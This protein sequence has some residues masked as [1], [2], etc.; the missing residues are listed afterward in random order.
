MLVSGDKRFIPKSGAIEQDFTP[1]MIAGTLLL[2]ATPAINGIGKVGNLVVDALNPL[3]GMRNASISTVTK[4]TS[5]KVKTTLKNMKETIS[6]E[7]K[8]IPKR[9]N[10]EYKQKANEALE[11]GNK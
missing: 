2:P 8:I 9:F 3:A 1:E 11:R 5:N 6:Y 7:S 10:S 4:E